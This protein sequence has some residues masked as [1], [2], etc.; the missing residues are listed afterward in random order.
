MAL[1]ALDIVCQ[2]L[3]NLGYISFIVKQLSVVTDLSSTL[4][5]PSGSASSPQ[6]YSRLESILI[7]C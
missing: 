4:M 7:A 3:W 5:D 1:Q 2:P 6:K